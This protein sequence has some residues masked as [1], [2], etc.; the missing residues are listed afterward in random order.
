MVVAV[1]VV[2]AA[3]VFV[4]AVVTTVALS[5]SKHFYQIQAYTDLCKFESTLFRERALKLSF[6]RRSVCPA[7][8]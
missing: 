6:P 5:E 3:V 4:V 1:V 7:N 2:V 8:V